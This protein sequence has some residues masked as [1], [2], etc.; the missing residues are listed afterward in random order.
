[1]RERLDRRAPGALA[2]QPRVVVDPGGLVDREAVLGPAGVA[3]AGALAEERGR[4]RRNGDGL[5]REDERAGSGQRKC[6]DRRRRSAEPQLD[7]DVAEAERLRE[8][9]RRAG[10]RGADL[11]GDEDD[12]LRR[13]VREQHLRRCRG[14]GHDVLVRAGHAPPTRLPR[15]AVG[16]GGDE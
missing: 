5:D 7:R 16:R 6:V 8:H 11:A 13:T 12:S 3:Q 2:Q 9:R 4:S 10:G 14:H 15:G 1:M